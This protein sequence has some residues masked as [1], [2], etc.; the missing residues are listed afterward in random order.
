[1]RTRHDRIVLY[2]AHSIRSYVPR[3]FEGRLPLF[4]IGTNGGTSCAPALSDRIAANCAASGRSH[5][6]DGR[7]RGGWTTRHYGIPA[8]GIHAVQME[9]ATR[10]YLREPDAMTSTSWPAPLDQT[11]AAEL[12]PVL[13]AVLDECIRFAGEQA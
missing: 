7:F 3:L 9:L 6:V 13:R 1:M 12:R 8:H 5:V 4:N 10:G 2:D 11:R